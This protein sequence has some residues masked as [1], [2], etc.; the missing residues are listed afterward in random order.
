MLFWR[1]FHL[2]HRC[3]NVFFSFETEP[4]CHYYK[5][6]ALIQE[7]HSPNAPK[8][9]LKRAATWFRRWEVPQVGSSYTWPLMTDCSPNRVILTVLCIM[10]FR[11]RIRCIWNTSILY[12]LLDTISEMPHSLI[13]NFP[14]SEGNQTLVVPHNLGNVINPVASN[15]HS[16]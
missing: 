2:T 9:V 10:T 4:W 11:L 6:S 8:P 3:F 15:V 12:C 13:A 1:K 7:S 14:E 16:F 5:L